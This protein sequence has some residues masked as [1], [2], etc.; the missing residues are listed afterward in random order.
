M[1]YWIYH[2]YGEYVL[3]YIF[4]SGVLNFFILNIVITSE[5]LTPKQTLTVCG[6]SFFFIYKKDL[7]LCALCID[8]E[9]LEFMNYPITK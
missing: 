9:Y 7:S 2:F 3:V 1:F 6:Q 5:A 8:N 4:L